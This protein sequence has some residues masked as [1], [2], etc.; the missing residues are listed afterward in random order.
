MSH[1][2]FDLTDQPITDTYPRILQINTPSGSIV[3]D[4]LGDPVDLVISGDLTVEGSV[5][6]SFENIDQYFQVIHTGSTNVNRI[7][8][9]SL[10]WDVQ[11]L[12]DSPFTHSTVTNPTRIQVG[13][14]A[15]YDVSYSILT[16][17]LG[18][19]R[20]SIQSVIRLNGFTNIQKTQVIAY[21][22]NKL[23]GGATTNVWSGLIQLSSSN[24]V[25]LIL[26]NAGGSTNAEVNT[27]PSSS[28]FTMRLVREL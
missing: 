4:G 12:L 28:L 11:D 6:G 16:E 1:N 20:T 21:K 10:S 15:W 14:S 18:N 26:S 24:F 2:E 13:I 25:E 9:V 19:V 7:T 5:S 8:P 22:R 23:T 3:L 27:I 17:A